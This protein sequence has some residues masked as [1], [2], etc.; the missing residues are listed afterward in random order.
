MTTALASIEQGT[1]E[2]ATWKSVGSNATHG[3]PRSQADKRKAILKALVHPRGQG[4]SDRFIAEAC[5]VSH[6]LV[7]QVRREQEEQGNVAKPETI[8]ARDG[9]T[10]KRERKPSRIRNA[11]STHAP[12]VDKRSS[13]QEPRV[14]NN[15]PDG[16]ITTS[17][18]STVA[19]Y[20]SLAVQV[21]NEAEYVMLLTTLAQ[22]RA[23]QQH[24][25]TCQCNQSTALDWQ[26][27]D[28]QLDA[29]QRESDEWA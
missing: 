11:T 3:L 23:T 19:N 18:S 6:I 25:T 5:K 9:K 26:S 21:D 27:N 22:Y 28:S 2:D 4:M 10:Y 24:C 16:S 14:N 20:T 8:I 12:T 13:E 15:V 17:P 1:L 7:A 29:T